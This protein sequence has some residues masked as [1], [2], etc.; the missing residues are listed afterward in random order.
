MGLKR[1]RKATDPRFRRTTRERT[2]RHAVGKKLTVAIGALGILAQ[3]T[4]SA[5]TTPASADPLG[6]ACSRPAP[7][8]L[9]GAILAT[10]TTIN[11]ASP[12]GFPNPGATNPAIGF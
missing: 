2:L 10:D 9:T 8:T 1:H 4:V 3:L 6:R 5:F 11:V 7:P 12:A